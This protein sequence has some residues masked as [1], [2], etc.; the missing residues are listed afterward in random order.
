MQEGAGGPYVICRSMHLGLRQLPSRPKQ[1]C[2]RSRR[3]LGAIALP[4][5][6]QEHLLHM[7]LALEAQRAGLT[8][9]SSFAL[10][11]VFLGE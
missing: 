8:G 2:G 7:R 5:G 6:Q 10:R 4:F 1:P 3:M 9:L 11:V